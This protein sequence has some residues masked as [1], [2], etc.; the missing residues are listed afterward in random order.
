MIRRQES[1]L[2]MRPAWVCMLFS[3]LL[4]STA[5][6]TLLTNGSEIV[7]RDR[8]VEF[9]QSVFNGEDGFT[10]F[11]PPGAESV[12]IVWRTVPNLDAEVLARQD[13]DIGISPD[14]GREVAGNKAAD[15]RTKPNN[16]GVAELVISTTTHP[17]LR[18]GTL[19]IGFVTQDDA[20]TLSGSITV[21]VDGGPIES[22]YDVEKSDFDAGLDGWTIN[23]TAAPYPGGTAGGRQSFLTH[24][25]ERGNPGGFARLTHRFLS[26]NDYYVAPAKFLTDYSKLVDARLEFDL[27]RINGDSVPNF[28]VDIRVFTDEGGWKWIGPNPP[29]I[30][31]EF[32]FFQNGFPMGWR[33]FSAP[34][35][36][37]FWVKLDGTA[38][39]SEA[40]ENPLRLEIRG[41]YPVNGGSVGLDNVRLRAR[42]QAPPRPVQPTVSS[43]SGGFDRWSR[44]TANRS[45]TPGAAVGD[46]DSVLQWSEEGGNGSGHIVL[47]ETHEA[48]GPNPD[49]FLPPGDFLGIYTDLDQPRFEFDYK[50]FGF[51]IGSEPDPVTIRIFG[52]N[53]TIYEWF[54]AA[55][56]GLWAHQ[57]APLEEGSWDLVSGDATFDEVLANIVR[58]EVSA[59]Q[60]EGR[61]R[62][63]LDNFA[64]LTADSPP[65]P[66]SIT[67]SPGQL[68]FSGAVSEPAPDPQ[69]IAISG[70]GLEVWGAAVQGSIAAN[71]SLSTTGGV[72]PSE[73]HVTV[74]PAGL[75]PGLHSFWIE[76]SS[77]GSTLDPAIVLGTLVLDEQPVPTPV[78]SQGGVVNAATNGPQLAAGSLGTIFG[79]NL[80]GPASGMVS[81]FGGARQDMLPKNM[82]GI[83][84]LVY[85][86]FG[87]LLAEAPIL[88]LS[89]KQIN[90]QMP[91]EAL[92]RSEVLIAVANGGVV[93]ERYRVQITKS[94]PGVFT[95]S[96]D[97]ATATNDLNQLASPGTPARR[98]RQLTIY[99]TGQG[100]VAPALETGRAAPIRPLVYAPATTQVFVGGVQS[101][102][103]FV[104]MTPGLVGVLQIN[105][106]LS[107]L[108]PA[109]RQPLTVNLNGFESPLTYVEV[110]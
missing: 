107:Y 77:P 65:L 36:E 5:S 18:A 98:N 106:E 10:F 88:Y 82:N 92:D 47:S 41:A 21:F 51:L 17:A 71:V 69:T 97:W 95:H 64:L 3:L 54:G 13:L 62:N 58:I 67:A 28:P 105:I 56:T 23:S 15:F 34:F 90:F 14:T 7:M 68:T 87:S 16:L 103:L 8:F 104:G 66:A 78:I 60:A 100:E 102:V 37:D 81:S 44:N 20:I 93:S 32:D 42:G 33:T 70:V 96:G 38:S 59:D 61:E 53:G 4:A 75:E 83:R 63:F 74:D 79:S 55:P 31:S 19:F 26:I 52:E 22:L 91:Y 72:F 27:A 108:T 45:T 73:L 1:P 12:R 80:G 85:E 110:E 30:P 86:T 35:R 46:D 40:M 39:F 2:V 49:A 94:A 25:P 89:D 57:V 6:A 109:G 99:M 11:V 43:F 24:E 48:G 76:I 50:H 101:K 9:S 29:A 84:V